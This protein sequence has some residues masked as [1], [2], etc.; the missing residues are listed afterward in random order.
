MH[1]RI[2]SEWNHWNKL[3]ENRSSVFSHSLWIYHMQKWSWSIPHH[4]LPMLRSLNSVY[5]LSKLG[6]HFVTLNFLKNSKCSVNPVKDARHVS[7]CNILEH[8]IS[9]VRSW[10]AIK[11]VF[12]T[13]QY[14]Q[15]VANNIKTVFFTHI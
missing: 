10:V 14:Q 12:S 11:S 8:F 7:L 15:R 13:A 4:L 3:N 2:L 9:T 5:N 1:S 6:I